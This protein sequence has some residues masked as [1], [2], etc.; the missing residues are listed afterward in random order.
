MAIIHKIV[1]KTLS[2]MNDGDIWI[3]HGAIAMRRHCEFVVGDDIHV[4]DDGLEIKAAV[5]RLVGLEELRR[6]NRVNL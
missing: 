2:K 3:V 4:D 1:R 5:D 6:A